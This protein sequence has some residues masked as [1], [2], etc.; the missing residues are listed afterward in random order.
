MFSL[1][2]GDV[3]FTF[4]E[5][6]TFVFFLMVR[7]GLFADFLFAVFFLRKHAPLWPLGFPCPEP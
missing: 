3:S 7:D 1:C 4:F 6:E 5:F 2:A